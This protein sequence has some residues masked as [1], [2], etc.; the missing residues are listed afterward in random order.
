MF[1]RIVTLL[2]AVVILGGISVSAAG[3]VSVLNLA[4]V[5]QTE[6]SDE[7]AQLKEL[8]DECE[9]IPAPGSN[10]T[11]DSLDEYTRALNYAQ[12]VYDNSSD[13]DEITYAKQILQSAIEG[14]TA[15]TSEYRDEL[16]SLIEEA[17]AI[18]DDEETYGISDELK[19][20]Y[21]NALPVYYYSNNDDE[22]KAACEALEKAIENINDPKTLE[23]AKE[24][25]KQAL[26]MYGYPPEGGNFTKDSFAAYE[27]ALQNAQ[28]AYDSSSDIDEINSARKAL[29]SAAEGLTAYT[30][31]YR[32]ELSSLMDEAQTILDNEETYGT[33][34]E[35][36][37]AFDDALPVYYYS[38][39]D[40]EVKAACEELKNAIEN[41]TEPK[42]VTDAK[43]ALKELLDEC[44]YIPEPGSNYTQDSFDTYSN[45]L[46]NAQSVYNTSSDT[47]EINAARKN[48]Q[49]A[50]DGLT[51]Y[52]S[53]YRDMLAELLAAAGDILE[54]DK[55]YVNY[56]D[57]KEVYNSALPVYYYGNDD[58]EVKAAYDNLQAAL[59]EY[60]SFIPSSDPTESADVLIVGDVDMDGNVTIIDALTLQRALVELITLTDDQE[61]AADVNGD[62][63]ISIDD[64]SAIQFYLLKDSDS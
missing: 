8:I 32:D 56:D 2:L 3:A 25:L 13:T 17:K 49:E 59:D 4:A 40:D 58:D 46:S 16:W 61:S 20:A 23:E 60:N 54:N 14:L 7:K 41:I 29:V 33:S 22:V 11:Q 48:L 24:A 63:I 30:S 15:Y 45:A 37:K 62:G 18:F 31:V 9:Y 21:N 5:S 55:D 19:E 27:E 53:E 28:T 1:K 34:E 12:L 35:L 26:D 51:A 39:D 38:N 6:I 52:T 43:K 47:D 42:T 44:E 57:L 36:K 10:Y 64:V 50:V